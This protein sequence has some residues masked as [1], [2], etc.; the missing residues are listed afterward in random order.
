VVLHPDDPDVERNG[1]TIDVKLKRTAS[2]SGRV[3]GELGKP[4]ADPVILLYSDLRYP[5]KFHLIR[6]PRGPLKLTAHRKSQGT[7]RSIRTMVSADAQA[8]QSNEV[9]IVLPDANERLR[10]IE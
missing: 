3:L 10:G 9:R 4:I 7:D 1:R 6:L 8:G 2:L 5:C